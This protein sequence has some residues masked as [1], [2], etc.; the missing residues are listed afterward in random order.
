MSAGVPVALASDQS[1]VPVSTSADITCYASAARTASPSNMADQTNNGAKGLLVV[2]DAT[3][4]AGG[5]GSIT[6]TI[7]GKDVASGKYYTILA[8]AAIVTVTTNQYTV[9]PT[10]TASANSIAQAA[11]PHTWR[12]IVTANNANPVT[13]SVGAS[14]LS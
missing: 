13:Y 2:V 6:V 10:L 7:Q 4:N 5:S 11:L 1:A 9:Y 12:V 8:S 14:Y 3:V